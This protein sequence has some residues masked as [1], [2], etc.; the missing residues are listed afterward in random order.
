[1]MS[2]RF[3][4]VACLGLLLSAPVLAQW[5]DEYVDT[6]GIKPPKP[7]RGPRALFEDSSKIPL[8]KWAVKS[9]LG[10]LIDFATPSLQAAVEHRFAPHWSVQMEAGFIF[11][12]GQG[13]A[14]RLGQLG[15]RLRPE[16]RYYFQKGW[17]S[18][19]NQNNSYLALELMHRQVFET[20]RGWFL[21]QQGAYQELL[22]YNRVKVNFAGHIKYGNIEHFKNSPWFIEYGF[23]L[24]VRSLY[25]EERGLPPDAVRQEAQDLFILQ[26]PA[27]TLFILPSM[28][29]TLKLGR[30]F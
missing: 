15:Y 19:S 21:R 22:E 12:Y 28:V 1:M 13:P 29:L 14:T 24:G 30:M 16:I 3:C 6:M 7:L 25:I 10:S 5:E 2:F 23:G 9:S 4:L 17:A 26:R 8:S 11:Q 20:Y 18:K 27:N